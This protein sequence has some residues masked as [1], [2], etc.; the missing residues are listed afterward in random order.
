MKPN[1]EFECQEGSNVRFGPL[2]K[3]DSLARSCTHGPSKHNITSFSHILTPFSLL[4]L[5]NFYQ[6]FGCIGDLSKE[7]HGKR[8]NFCIGPPW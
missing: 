6:P 2:Q 8:M 5:L 1:V 3:I 4:T 7:V